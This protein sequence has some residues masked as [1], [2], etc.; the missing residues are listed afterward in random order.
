VAKEIQIVG[1]RVGRE[2]FG[3]PIG[4]VHEIVRPPQITAVPQAPEYVEGV[5]NLRGRIV[6]V[7]DLRRR[8]G[9]PA[10]ANT[11]KNRVVIVSSEGRLV[12]L[13][14]DA[15]SEVLKLSETQIE[16]APKVLAGDETN[17]VTGVAKHQDRLIILIDLKKIVQPG[18]L[19]RLD[20]AKARV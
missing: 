16:A 13:M 6:P 20:D 14:V 3:L 2:S 9:E 11:G 8:F 12:G 19:R 17:F 18:E 5:I 10:A 15:A 1:F 4:V 7:I